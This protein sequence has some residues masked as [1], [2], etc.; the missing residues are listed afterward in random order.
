MNS[1]VPTS[2]QKWLHAVISKVLDSRFKEVSQ[3]CN[4]SDFLQW[5]IENKQKNGEPI[6]QMTII[7]HCSTFLL[8]G[9]ETSSSLMAFALLEVISK[10]KSKMFIDFSNC[11]SIVFASS[12][13]K[14]HMFKRRYKMKLM[15]LY[16]ATMVIF[17][18][19]QFR[20]CLIWKHHYMVIL[21]IISFNFCI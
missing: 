9:F 7:G 20:K 1:Y 13:P 14:I 12:M 15:K 3:S 16:H 19:R 17:A 6:N 2:V 5:L 10:Y 18:M 11:I 21:Y 4:K 8:E